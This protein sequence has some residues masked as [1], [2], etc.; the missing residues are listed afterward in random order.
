MEKNRF[1]QLL[2]SKSGDVKPL[3]TE[4]KFSLYEYE[5]YDDNKE[6]IFNQLV[7]DGGQEIFNDLGVVV[8]D[9]MTPDTIANSVVSSQMCQFSDMNTYAEKTFGE[10]VRNKFGDGAKEIMEK[11]V[12]GLNSF[13]EMVKGFGIKQLKQLYKT[14]KVKKTEA[15]KKVSRKDRLVNE[16]F[17]TSMAIVTIGSFAMPALILTI[18]SVALVTIIGIYILKSILCA[19]NI[20]F[21]NI[22]GCSVQSFEWGQCN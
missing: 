11:I 13:V 4:R 22:R 19:F 6:E 8:N 5:I 14:L 3:I 10:K 15:E 20:S 18:V 2:E 9:T 21:Q 17:G 1:K 7:S 16:F 12:S